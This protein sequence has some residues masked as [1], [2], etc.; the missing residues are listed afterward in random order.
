MITRYIQYKQYSPATLETVEEV[1]IGRE[2]E[3]QFKRMSEVRECLADYNSTT[4]GFGYYYLSNRA[5]K[6]WIQS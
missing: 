3:A 2:P 5:C 4:K 1:T 6:H